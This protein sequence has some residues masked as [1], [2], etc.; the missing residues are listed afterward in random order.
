MKEVRKGVPELNKVYAIVRGN[1]FLLF[2][3]TFYISM[4]IQEMNVF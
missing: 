2:Q 1:F 3:N 4:K